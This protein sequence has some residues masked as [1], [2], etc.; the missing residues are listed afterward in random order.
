MPR[1]LLAVAL[2]VLAGPSMTRADSPPRPTRAPIVRAVDLDVGETQRVVLAD[3]ASATVALLDVCEDKDPIR[4]AV[5]QARLKVAVNGQPITLS[6]GQYHLPQP[7]GGV[8]VDCPIT[9]GYRANSNED[10]WSLDKAARLRLWPA[11]SP[12]IEPETFVYPLRQRWFASMAQ[13]ANEPTYVD[14]GEKPDVKTIYYYSGLDIGGAE[15]LAEVVAAADGLVVV[16]GTERLPGYDDAPH[17]PRYDVVCML[18]D[19][20]WY[21]R[22]RHMQSI[23]RATR[24]GAT[25]KKGQTIGRLGKEGGAAGRTCTSRSRAGSR[26]ASGR[27]R[28]VRRSSGRPTCART[29][30]N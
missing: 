2:L 13:M 9:G 18:D 7:V 22:Y 30:R 8:Q 5:R 20:G 21:F 26:P 19:H 16:S 15:G 23:D 27:P 24:P 4:H 12:W 6:A 25:V 14:G 29:G 28:R 1:R 10:R 11:G 3:G 17:E